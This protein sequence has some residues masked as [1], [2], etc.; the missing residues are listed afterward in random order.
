MK[1]NQFLIVACYTVQIMDSHEHESSPRDVSPGSLPVHKSPNATS[2]CST[3]VLRAS[4][5]LSRR[6]K[7]SRGNSKGLEPGGKWSLPTYL[8]DLPIKLTHKAID[9]PTRTQK[10]LSKANDATHGQRGTKR[11][12]S[13]LT[14]SQHPTQPSPPTPTSIS[15][16]GCHRSQRQKR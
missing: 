7:L 1:V 14:S 4:V 13:E 6:Q 9:Q 16:S 11:K 8:N 2:P 3:P 15:Y 12:M 5:R 10:P